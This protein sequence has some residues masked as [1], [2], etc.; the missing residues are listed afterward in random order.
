MNHGKNICKELKAIRK[1]IAD[2]NDIPLQQEECHYE[3][4]CDGT[5]PH[6]DAELQYLENELARRSG[7]GALAKVAGL[8]LGLAACTSHH[9]LQGKPPANPNPPERLMGEPAVLIDTIEVKGQMVDARTREPIPFSRVIIRRGDSPVDTL[10]TDINGFFSVKLPRGEYN[11][12][13]NSVGYEPKVT[14]FMAA[15]S[16]GVSTIEIN[17]E[18][19]PVLMGLPPV[20]PVEVGPDGPSQQMEVEGVK[21]KVR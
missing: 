14:T 4:E 17:P 13:V 1:H 5:C 8:V 19:I 3:G 11:M 18:V 16:E 10:Q 7:K 2:E 9:P 12:E 6:C 21:V 15:P 20:R